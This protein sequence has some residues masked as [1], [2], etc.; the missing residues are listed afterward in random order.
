MLLED[1]RRNVAL[2]FLRDVFPTVEA[3][4]PQATGCPS[5][6][7]VTTILQCVDDVVWSILCEKE[8]IKVSAFRYVAWRVIDS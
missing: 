8:D 2:Q 1:Y 5:G 4:H 3:I 6:Y 7:V